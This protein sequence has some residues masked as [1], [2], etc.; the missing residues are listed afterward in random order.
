MGIKGLFQRP[1]AEELYDDY[2][3]EEYSEDYSAYHDDPGPAPSSYEVPGAQPIRSVADM[4]IATVMPKAYSDAAQIAN[5][6]RDMKLVVMNVSELKK[7]APGDIWRIL[8]F[9]SGVAY[10]EDGHI[11]KVAED[12][13]VAAPYFV[14]LIDRSNLEGRERESA[15]LY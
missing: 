8:D 3:E 12:V 6:L 5:M 7:N 9:L 11:M 15:L 2:Y 13:Y 14:D 10:S 4:Q 1:E